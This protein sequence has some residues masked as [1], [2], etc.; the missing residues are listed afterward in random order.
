MLSNGEYLESMSAKSDATAVASAIPLMI[1]G[2]EVILI[3]AYN[4][5]CIRFGVNR[6]EMISDWE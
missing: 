4:F 6:S 2:A 3:S 5:A 1:S